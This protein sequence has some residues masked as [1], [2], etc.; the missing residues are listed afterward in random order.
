MIFFFSKKTR[1]TREFKWLIIITHFFQ[2]WF[3]ESLLFLVWNFFSKLLIFQASL[4]E[5]THVVKEI[6]DFKKRHA[7]KV[8]R[9][10]K[11]RDQRV[12]SNAIKLTEKE[13]KKRKRAANKDKK[14]QENDAKKKRLGFLFEW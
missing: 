12:A 6:G 14:E 4:K 3:F 11:E 2:P 1:A 10:R 13:E 5:E 9:E 7:Q 8:E